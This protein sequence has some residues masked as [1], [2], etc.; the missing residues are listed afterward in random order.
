MSIVL[1]DIIA[2]WKSDRPSSAEHVRTYY[3]EHPNRIECL[4]AVSQQGDILGFQSLQRATDGNP[5]G[6]TPGWGFIGTY[7][8][9]DSGRRGIG[10]A[11]FAATRDAARKA[12]LP[13]IDATIGEHNDLGLAYYEAMGFRTYRR[14]PGM[15]SKVY[16]L[17]P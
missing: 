5:W 14:Q 4:V 3:V 11:L 6:V 1:R 13:S 16:T 7:V 9:L 2:A 10:T 17:F 15:I 12:G 8:K